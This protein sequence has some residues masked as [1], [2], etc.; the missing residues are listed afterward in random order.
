MLTSRRTHQPVTL[1]QM[2][3]YALQWPNVVDLVAIAPYYIKFA[4]GGPDLAV[5]R[6]LRLTRVLALTKVTGASEYSY[7]LMNTMQ[8]STRVLIP[9]CFVVCLA[10]VLFGCL[11]YVVEQGDFRVNPAYPG[12][13]YIRKNVYGNADEVSP[14]TAISASLYY[15]VVTITTVG[16]G[17]LYPTR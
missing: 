8:R 5:F 6:V 13:A 9:L 1:A 3:C 7:V 17:D 2:L 4:T 15:V 14:F 16:Y 10:I 11:I 12:G